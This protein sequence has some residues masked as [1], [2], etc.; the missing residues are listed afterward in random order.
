MNSFYA[1][2]PS[3]LLT[4]YVKQYWFLS[5]DGIIQGN[6]RLLPFGCVG[7]TF[8]R[9]H[10]TSFL[11]NS[12]LPSAYISGQSTVYNDLA[13]NGNID[14]VSIVFEP[15]GA[16]QFFNIPMNEISDRHISI[17]DLGDKTYIE[18]KNKLAETT[19]NNNCIKI[20]EDFLINKLYNKEEY[21]YKRLSHIMKFINN[22]VDDAVLL[23]KT[24]C[25]GYKQFKR[26][27]YDNIGINPKEYIRINRFQK[28]AHILQMNP[29]ITLNDLAE[30]NKYYDKSHLIRDFKE[31]SGYKPKEYIALCDPYSRYHALFRSAFLD[32]L[33]E[34]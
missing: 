1:I 6:Q 12:L 21:R 23:A 25:L 30:Q 29:A 5:L 15:V 22:D 10:N 16:M 13:F 28:T 3:P 11:D 9:T 31:F 18:L 33:S 27:F 4:P 20:I 7:L 26:T 24:A 2:Q 32:S 19:D 8:H 14:S 17:D 34:Q